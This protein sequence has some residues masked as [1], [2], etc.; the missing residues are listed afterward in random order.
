MTDLES[1][2]VEAGNPKLKDSSS[3]GD[4]SSNARPRNGAIPLTLEFRGSAHEYFRIWIVNLCLTLLTLG[5]FSPWA[6][7]RKK[8]YY[9]SHTILDGTPFQYLG[10]PIPILKGRLIAAVLF[11]AYFLASHFFHFMLPYVLIPALIA[12]PWMLMRSM[13]FNARYSAFRNMTFNFDANYQTAARAV[14][15]WAV[16]PVFVGAMLLNWWERPKVAVWLFVFCAAMFPFWM[17]TL[18]T[19]LVKNTSFGGKS[20]EF[21]A[22]CRAY[23]WIYFSAAVLVFLPVTAVM[24][25]FF[26]MKL[27]LAA[28]KVLRWVL[29]GLSYCGYAVAYSFVQARVSN[30]AWNSTRV[31]PLRFQSDLRASGMAG[32]YFSNA[33]AIIVSAG[34]L[35]PWALMRTLKYRASHMKVSCVGELTEFHGDASS[36]V[37]AVGAETMD[38][39]DLDIAL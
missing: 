6:K 38:L 39:F 25:V 19:F 13:A 35:I 4:N 30:L 34:L 26:K 22:S 5:L 15:E 28:P 32:L 1:T 16:S 24:I 12:A 3:E 33:L 20:G 31:G 2:V 21:T 23:G 36:A 29:V 11:S 18:R 9:Y 10:Q 27:Y 8:R 37:S 7:V 14:F 17:C